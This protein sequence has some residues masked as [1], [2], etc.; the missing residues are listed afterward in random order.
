[1]KVLVREY[2]NIF[3]MFNQI[4]YYFYYIKNKDI[5]FINLYNYLFCIVYRAIGLIS[6]VFTNGPG[7]QS[8]IP[9]QVIRKTNKMVLDY[10]FECKN[11]TWL[12]LWVYAF[13]CKT[14]HYKVKWHPPQHLSEVAN[15]EGAFG[16]PSPKVAKFTYFIYIKSIPKTTSAQ[17]PARI[18]G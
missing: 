8:S 12:C 9:G 11:G 7:I 13:E 18:R 14:Q 10:A 5:L 16:S 3:T 15:K 2:M 4:I 6:R 17:E 1:M